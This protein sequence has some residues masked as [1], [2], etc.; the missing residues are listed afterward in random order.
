MRYHARR[1]GFSDRDYILGACNQEDP[2]AVLHT[3]DALRGHT[4][5]WVIVGPGNFAPQSHEYA[6][7]RAIGTR[8]DSLGVRL[9]GSMRLGDAAP[10]D[11]PTAYRFDMSDTTRLSR[12]TAD[13]Y[14]LSPLVARE[15][16]RANKWNC[17]GVFAPT[18]RQSATVI[19]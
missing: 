9:P 8:T 15:L 18:V 14:T 2:R 13:S 19:R 7:L 17:Y 16:R 4:R 1:F 5:A 12:A 6:Y 11:I 3:V 10:F